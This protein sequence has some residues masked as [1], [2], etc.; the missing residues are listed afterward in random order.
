MVELTVVEGAVV[1]S[2]FAWRRWWLAEGGA[3]EYSLDTYV[4]NMTF[5]YSSRRFSETR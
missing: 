4:F 1:G 2:E 3:D 5:A